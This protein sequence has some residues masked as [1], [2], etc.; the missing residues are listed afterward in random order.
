V[1]SQ[2]SAARIAVA[3]GVTGRPNNPTISVAG[4]A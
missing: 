4:M 1:Q 2:E 3:S